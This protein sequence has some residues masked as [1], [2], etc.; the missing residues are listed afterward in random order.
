MFS[1]AMSKEQKMVK[2]EFAKFVKEMVT[3]AAHDMDEEGK[4]P[5]DVIQKAWELGASISMIPEEYG[6]FGM[7]DSPV[8]TCLILEELAY[9]DMSFAVAATL[10]SLFIHPLAEMGTAAQK[11]KY[12]PLYCGETYAPCTLA[13]QE[14]HY[15]FDPIDLKTKATRKNG[16]FIL[17]GKKCF[18]P[19]AGMSNHLMVAAQY[20]GANNLFIVERDN[21]GVAIGEPEKNLGLNAL[22]TNEI[23]LENCEIP[24]EDRL[25]GDNGCDFE[26][27]LQKM[28]IAIS[29]MGT[30][31][32]RASLE[33]AR[34][35][36]LQRVQFGEP[37]VFRQSVA[38]MLAEMAY[39]VDAMRLMTWKA[40]SKLENGLD[41]K[42]ESYL[43]KLYAGEMTMKVT[44]HGVQVLGG[45]GYIRDYPQERCYRNGR[46]ISILEGIAIL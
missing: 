8:E 1:F 22:E 18:V 38:F 33:F 7:K 35:Y 12:L 2:E 41:A 39:E 24:V 19:M 15:G 10:P 40:A 13:L 37:I 42:R 43:A 26:R 17:N 9:G 36:A 28:R 11:K 29:A 14:P 6:G 23:V 25:G 16:S 27:L 34:N 3:D 30:G 4:I 44:D 5:D 21:S 20:E 31:I 46:G 45:H 32:S